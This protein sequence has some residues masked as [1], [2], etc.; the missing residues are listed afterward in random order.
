MGSMENRLQTLR[1]A[2]GWSQAEMAGRLGVS[3]QTINALET[4]RYDPS[5]TLGIRIARLFGVAVEET[6]ILPEENH[7]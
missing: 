3:R 4:G 7:P 6:F 2:R 5:M 1:A